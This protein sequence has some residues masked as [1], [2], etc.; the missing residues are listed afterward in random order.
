MQKLRSRSF[1]TIILSEEF[2]SKGG[3]ILEPTW[4]M[5]WAGAIM[6]AVLVIFTLGKSPVFRVDRAG[7]AIIGSVLMIG[8]GVLSF[9]EASR[10]VDQKTIV[11]LFSLMVL[12]ANLKLAGFF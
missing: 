10:A 7:A 6:A 5:F 3:N 2:L 12:V 4:N 8:T 1:C 9:E 11:I